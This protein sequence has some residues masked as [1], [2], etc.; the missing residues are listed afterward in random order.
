MRSGTYLRTP[1]IR[2]KNRIGSMGHKHS[3]EWKKEHSRK[4]SGNGNPT[5]GKKRDPETVAKIVAKTRGQK[6]TIE[7]RE[8]LKGIHSGERN[9]MYG[10]HLPGMKGDKNP[11]WKG[12]KT[13]LHVSIRTC[14]KYR[15]WRDDVFTRDDFTCQSCFVRGGY[16]EAH[17]IKRVADI[18]DDYSLKTM[19]QAYDCEELWSLNN[20][21]TL[22]EECHDKITFGK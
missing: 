7:Q 12:G 2:E 1:E 4:M 22:C 5:Y 8:K 21:V 3:D 9:P 15:M 19:E 13:P 18:M 10:I 11:M 16:L 17:H 14:L 6:R 20:G